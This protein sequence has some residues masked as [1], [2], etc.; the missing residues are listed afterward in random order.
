VQ[1]LACWPGGIE[2]TRERGEEIWKQ[3]K[4]AVC[5]YDT[6]TSGR[7]YI[8]EGGCIFILFLTFL[9]LRAP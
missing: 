3:P 9:F 8:F 6:K 1:L 5:F 4:N 2:N 7:F